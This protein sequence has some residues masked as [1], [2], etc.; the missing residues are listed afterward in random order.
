[1]RGLSDHEAGF[2]RWRD[3]ASVQPKG[4]LSHLVR[5]DEGQDLVEYAFLIVFIALTIIGVFQATEGSISAVYQ[6]IIAT[7]TTA[8]S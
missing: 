6:R 3:A 7:V 5:G 8:G 1:M 4:R 2:V